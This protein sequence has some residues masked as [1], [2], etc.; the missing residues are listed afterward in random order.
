M[1]YLCWRVCSWRMYI[2]HHLSLSLSCPSGSAQAP[3]VPTLDTSF[4]VGCAQTRR[5]KA[6]CII[7]DYHETHSIR[8]S[9]L[10]LQHAHSYFADLSIYGLGS[11]V[12]LFTA[13]C[14]VTMHGGAVV[15]SSLP[16]PLLPPP[17][18]CKAHHHPP[19]RVQQVASGGTATQFGLNE[20]PRA[21]FAPSA[22][23]TENSKSGSCAV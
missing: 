20:I 13:P 17:A 16:S 10:S 6:S 5:N 7:V 23:S 11:K 8:C 2:T 1:Y 21:P 4:L 18:G 14:H 3:R 9:R 22:P 19:L 12:A 15:I